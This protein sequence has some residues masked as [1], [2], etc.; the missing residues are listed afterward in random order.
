MAVRVVNI[1]P[2]HRLQAVI[3]D[4]SH[5]FRVVACGRRWGKTVMA[6]REALKMIMRRFE[7]QRTK[8]RCWIV[9]PTFPLVREDWL[10]AET[11]FEGVI[12]NKK[13]FSIMYFSV[14]VRA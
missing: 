7:K 3:E 10:I 14:T 1:L 13:L 12:T 2:P 8:Q 5:R 4:D 11:L 6:M 9:A